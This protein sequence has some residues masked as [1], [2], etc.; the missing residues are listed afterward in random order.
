MSGASKSVI[1]RRVL[2]LVW[3]GIVLLVAFITGRTVYRE[4]DA[5]FEQCTPEC[6]LI[7]FAGAGVEVVLSAA[8]AVP[9]FSA[10]RVFGVDI[11]VVGR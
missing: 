3:W 10:W 4:Q 7:G 9:T 11:G 6:D 1:P 8:T 5:A 2:E